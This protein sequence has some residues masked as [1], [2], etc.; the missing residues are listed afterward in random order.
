LGQYL[1]PTDR[2][3]PVARYVPPAEFAGYE[4]RAKAMGFRGV[5]AAPLVRSSYR[6]QSIHG[7]TAAPK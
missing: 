3:L 7:T 1:Q 5:A 4:E 6:A 2:Q